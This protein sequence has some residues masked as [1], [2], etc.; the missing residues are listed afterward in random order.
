VPTPPVGAAG[1]RSF[2]VELPNSGAVEHV[3]ER[4]RAGG[5]DVQHIDGSVGVG[6]PAGNEIVLSARD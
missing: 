5:I 1:L 2:A 6:D 4:L 3:V